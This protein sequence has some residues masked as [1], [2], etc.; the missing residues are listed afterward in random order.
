MV[1]D[2]IEGQI[3]VIELNGQTL[4]IPIEM[5]PEGVQEGDRLRMVLDSKPDGSQTSTDRLARLQA[6][7]D[8]PDHI[9]L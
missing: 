3:V 1:V 4:D 5:L 6:K 9:D 7:D 8:L 2:R